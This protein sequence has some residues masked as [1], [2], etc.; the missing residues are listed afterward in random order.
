MIR[1]RGRCSRM[2]SEDLPIQI[3]IANVT[4]LLFSFL[5]VPVIARSIGADGRGQTAAVVAAFVFV[6]VVLGVGLP[7]EVRRRSTS[8]VD[9]YAV[10]AARDITC[11]MFLPAA[12]IGIL[13]VATIFRETDESVR[14]L[15]GIGLAAAPISVL[16]AI[17]AGA[18]VGSGR[19]R[20]VFLLRVAQPSLVLGLLLPIA[21]LGH[22]T[23]GVTLTVYLIGNL[24]TAI[25]GLRLTRV[26]FRGERAARREVARAG[27]SY[28]GSAIAESAAAKADQILVLPLIGATETGYY[29]L[30]TSIS[31]LPIAISHALAA[32]HFR[33]VAVAD[34]SQR[35]E[36]GRQGLRECASLAAPLVVILGL[37]GVA[38]IP[39]VFGQEFGP[40]TPV[41]AILI[42][43]SFAMAISYVGS[44]LLAAQGRGGVMT[45]TQLLALVVD[46]GLLGPLTNLADAKGAALASTCSYVVLLAMQMVALRAPVTDLIPTPDRLRSGLRSLAR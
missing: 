39:P 31:V 11:A 19:Y 20:A 3:T 23:P 15:A 40:S 29:T 44:M 25:L 27:V 2:L 4:S 7:L 28:C 38:L 30:A 34:E 46:L 36:F 6:P 45:A 13:A 43:G 22:L 35:H 8:G 1:R 10:R 12:A 17:D 37:A 32:K 41:L 5:T 42:P 33:R 24:S 14:V 26:S 16:W 21:V 9:P 18:L